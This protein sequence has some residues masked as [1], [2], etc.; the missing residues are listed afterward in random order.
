MPARIS[1]SVTESI[2]A[3]GAAREV[4][5]VGPVGRVADREALGDRVGLL[6]LADVRALRERRR[7]R[8]AALGL[9]A[10]EGRQLALDQAEL[11]PLVDAA[12]E[13]GEQRA[14]GDRADDAVGQLPA[15]LLDRLV[16]E[17]LR[18][19]GVVGAQVDVDEGPRARLGELGAE[20]VDVVVVAPDADQVGAVDAGREQL[21][22]LEVGGDEDVGVE[23][24]GGGVRR[25]RVR[26]VAGRGAGHGLEAELLGLRDRDGDHAVLERVRRVGGVVLDPELAQ[27]E[28]LGEAV[29]ADQR[30]QAGLERVAG[31]A[32]R[33]AGSRRSARSRASPAW[34][35]RRA[36]AGRARRSRSGPRAGRSSSRRRRRR[37][38][39]SSPRTPCISAIRRHRAPLRKKT[40]AC[41]CG[42]R[43]EGTSSHIFQA[44][45]HLLDLAPSSDQRPRGLP[46]LHRASPSTPLDVV[47]M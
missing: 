19:L 29:G 4:E 26:E 36:S 5:R 30:R 11:E 43:S 40:S 22:L 38:A 44:F 42:R 17:R 46:G 10:A 28:P 8:G 14:R 39:R 35:L 45:L 6:R 12:A 31:R 13:L 7:D 1:S 20:P 3:A 41:V 25:D 21:L 2:S 18:A 27:A 33:T 9:G 15:E 16:G 24:G 37:R 34:I 32:R 23:A 47:L